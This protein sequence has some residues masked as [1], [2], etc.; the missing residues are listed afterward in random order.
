MGV[1]YGKI[2]EG[3]VA[4]VGNPHPKG[5][6]L[7]VYKQI[8][9]QKDGDEFPLLFTHKEFI[10]A[11]NRAKKH[12]ELI[13]SNKKVLGVFGGVKLGHMYKVARKKYHNLAANRYFCVKLHTCFEG[14]QWFAFTY[15]AFDRAIVR[16]YKNSNIVIKKKFIIDVFD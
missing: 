11:L 8:W 6:Q 13:P 9:V 12:P 5:R 10:E 15:N 16:T 3:Y 14:T 4:E 1:I 2:K 7:S